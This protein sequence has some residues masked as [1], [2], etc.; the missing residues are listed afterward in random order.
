[1]NHGT[2]SNVS[3]FQA[4]WFLLTTVSWFN[5]R[6]QFFKII[7]TEKN[8]HN[9]KYQIKFELQP[10]VAFCAKIFK[11]ILNYVKL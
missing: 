9:T 11:R 6:E 3:D 2:D 8:T 7:I 5:N 4:K 10:T 1:M